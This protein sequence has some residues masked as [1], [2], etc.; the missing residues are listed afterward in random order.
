MKNQQLKT[1]KNSGFSLLEVLLSITILTM[2]LGV[3][4]PY[5]YDSFLREG[6][7]VMSTSLVHYLQSARQR[8][9]LRAGDYWGV[10]FDSTAHEFILFNGKDFQGRNSEFDEVYNYNSQININSSMGS[11]GDVVFEP[12][13]GNLFNNQIV[14]IKV[15]TQQKSEPITVLSSGVIIY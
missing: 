9:T 6:Q 7:Q 13:T 4:I 12:G 10:H 5:F 3:S 14:D 8:A 15:Y 1:R 2:L 11:S